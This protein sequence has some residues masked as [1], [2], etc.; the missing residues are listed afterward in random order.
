MLESHRDHRIAMAFAIA[1]QL[2]D[3]EVRVND[4]ANVVTSSRASTRWRALPHSVGR[5]RLGCGRGPQSPAR[6]A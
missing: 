5:C 6:G 2:A 4:V 1:G 3:G